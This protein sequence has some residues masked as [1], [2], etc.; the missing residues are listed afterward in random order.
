MNPC[1]LFGTIAQGLIN[2]LLRSERET[3]EIN[4]LALT[5]L[6]QMRSILICGILTKFDV[7]DV[8]TPDPVISGPYHHLL[9]P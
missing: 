2:M 5:L 1:F 3:I 9:F 6:E 8:G 7:T 4:V